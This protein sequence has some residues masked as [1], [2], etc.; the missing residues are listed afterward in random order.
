MKKMKKINKVLYTIFFFIVILA[1]TGC[2]N[3]EKQQIIINPDE[4]VSRE[5]FEDQLSNIML[6]Y[7][8]IIAQ[9]NDKKIEFT[10]NNVKQNFE[11]DDSHDNRIRYILLLILTK[12]KFYDLEKALSL[13]NDWPETRQL[14][15]PLDSFRKILIMR[16]TEEL[17]LRKLVNRLSHQLANEKLETEMLHKKINDI[18][19]MEKS[20]I[21]RNM[22]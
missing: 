4:L 3:I 16:L 13:L 1:S 6:D 7:A 19:D 11:R 8:S 22:P 17:R 18:K 14:P 10:F 12:Q 2:S 20:L 21:R 5:A 9:Q 15:V